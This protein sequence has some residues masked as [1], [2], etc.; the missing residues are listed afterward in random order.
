MNAKPTAAFTALMCG[1]GVLVVRRWVGH[2][3]S[4]A[5]KPLAL[6][7]RAFVYTFIGSAT[8]TFDPLNVAPGSGRPRGPPPRDGNDGDEAGKGAPKPRRAPGA[9]SGTVASPKHHKREGG[10]DCALEGSVIVTPDCVRRARRLR[11]GLSSPARSRISAT[12]LRCG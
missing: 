2:M 11:W 8:D 10:A 4:P 5:L 12:Q 6:A 1:L 9:A 3:E 7:L